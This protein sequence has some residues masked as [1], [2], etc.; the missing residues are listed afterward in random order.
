MTTKKKSKPKE[1]IVWTN[2]PGGP[3]A[4]SNWEATEVKKF[5]KEAKK[6]KAR[7]LP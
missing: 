2:A 4:L 6:E 5:A 3:R 1:V 7:I